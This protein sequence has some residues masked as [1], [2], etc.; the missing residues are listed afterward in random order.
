MWLLK[1]FYKMKSCQEA[2]EI[3][4]KFVLQCFQVELQS[5]FEDFFANSILEHSQNS[6]S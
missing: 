5:R 6:S 1:K 3:I 2:S 4:N